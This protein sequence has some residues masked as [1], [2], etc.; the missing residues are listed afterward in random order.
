MPPLSPCVVRAPFQIELKWA[1]YTYS[2]FSLKEN[3]LRKNM[4]RESLIPPCG[5]LFLHFEPNQLSLIRRTHCVGGVFCHVSPQC[6]S[7]LVLQRCFSFS[8]V[9]VL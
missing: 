7:K 6:S 3:W 5:P 1:Q 9:D 2:A 8:D 4:G